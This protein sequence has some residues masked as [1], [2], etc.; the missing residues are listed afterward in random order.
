MVVKES[1]NETTALIMAI[2][3]KA[4]WEWKIVRQAIWASFL[5]IN[6]RKMMGNP[7]MFVVEIGSL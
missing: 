7:A 3:Q 5:K 6:P 1:G 2:R 4:V